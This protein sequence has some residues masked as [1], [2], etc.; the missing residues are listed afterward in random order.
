MG[1]RRNTLREFEIIEAR[2]AGETGTAIAQRLGISHQRVY[3]VWKRHSREMAR[4]EAAWRKDL[5]G[6][7]AE[8]GEE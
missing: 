2:L 1:P 4:R 3:A 8:I 5:P 6:I 7:L